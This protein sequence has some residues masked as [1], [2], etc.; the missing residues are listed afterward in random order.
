MSTLQDNGSIDILS[1]FT[2][3]RY[4]LELKLRIIGRLIKKKE[5]HYYDTYQNN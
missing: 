5:R 2:L 4:N 1:V 3:N